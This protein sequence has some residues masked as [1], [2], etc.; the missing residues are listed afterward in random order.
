M[1]G[2]SEDVDP[3]EADDVPEGL[4]EEGRMNEERAEIGFDIAKSHSP[5]KRCFAAE[6]FTVAEVAPS[7]HCLTE[8]NGGHCHI[9]ECEEG[10]LLSSRHIEDCECAKNNTAVN[11][12]SAIPYGYDIIER[13]ENVFDKG[14]VGFEIAAVKD[15]EVESC[16]DDRSDDGDE[17]DVKHIVEDDALLLRAVYEVAEGSEDRKADDET[18]PHDREGVAGDIKGECHAIDHELVD[19]ETGK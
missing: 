17:R 7:A 8:H 10:D 12:K 16:A 1:T 2:L 3:D 14:T 6:R 5:G 4:I 18:V 19:A 11:G 15:D 9:A 13:A